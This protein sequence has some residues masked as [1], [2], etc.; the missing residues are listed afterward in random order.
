MRLAIPQLV[1]GFDREGAVAVRSA[2]NCF[3]R[4]PADLVSDERSLLHF[5]PPF[6]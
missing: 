1:A 6:G 4:Q 5:K 2:H 3:D